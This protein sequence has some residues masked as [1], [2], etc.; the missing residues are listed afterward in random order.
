MEEGVGVIT[1]TIKRHSR[2]GFAVETR[3]VPEDITPRE[4]AEAL[5]SSVGADP[6]MMDAVNMSDNNR[7]LM[8]A[9]YIDKSFRELGIR[10]GDVLHIHCDVHQGDYV[11]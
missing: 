10:N 11:G 4:F 8:S 3:T 1:L 2:N 9:P 7:E 6:N 5:L